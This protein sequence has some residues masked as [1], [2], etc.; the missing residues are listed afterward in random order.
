MKEHRRT[1]KMHTDEV[2]VDTS[3]VRVLLSSQ[4]PHWAN[5]DLEPLPSTGTDNAIYRLGPDMGV[6]LPRIHWA[7]PQIDK[8]WQWL[9]RLQPHLPVQV[10]VPLAKGRPGHGYPYP[11]LVFPW[12]DGADLQHNPVSDLCQLAR[13]VAAF[14]RTL[15]AIDTIDGPAAGRRGGPLAPHDDLTR[16]AISALDGV[17]DVD[18]ALAVW[19]GAVA[20]D[21][22]SEPPVW[23]HGD[24]LGGNILVWDGQLSGVI[25]WSAAGVGDPACDT[26]LAWSLPPEARA[27]FRVALG[28]D[29]ATWA[30]ARGWT[31]EQAAFFIP[32]YANTIPDSVAVSIRRLH[33][34]LAED[35]PTTEATE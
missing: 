31:V 17:V 2:H 35:E 1:P 14:V 9:E 29:D 30:R 19:E 28:I 34:V 18:R 3:L 11:W 22:W 5:L 20:A 23:V 12:L 33:A 8:E 16:S 21:P 6:R 4:F 15:R 24:L 13:D 10:P 32:Y 25:D 27:V 7:V 26:M